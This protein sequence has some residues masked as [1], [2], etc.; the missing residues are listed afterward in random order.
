MNISKLSI[1]RGVTF[2]M[3]YLIA[4][5]FG[6]YGLLQ[7]KLDL[8]PS[9]EFP[10]V[11][12][13]TNYEGVGPEDVE[14]LVTRPL[15]STVI[16][17][18]GVKRVTSQSRT[19]ASVVFIEFN[20]GTDMA[21]AENDVRKNIDFVRDFFPQEVSEPLT[22]AFN[23]SLQPILFFN[24]SS[25]ILGDAE[26]RK[27]AEEQIQPRLE[28]LEGVARIQVSGGLEREIQVLI[29][30]Y[31]L[32]ANS[33]SMDQLINALRF[34]NLE[35][36]GGILEEGR[37][38]FAIKT[39]AAFE[40]V[41]QIRNAVVGYSKMGQP[42]YLQNV[43]NLVDGYKEQTQVVRN[44]RKNTIILIAY[45]QT[46]ANTVN[47]CENVIN[48]LPNLEKRIG[49]DV[50]FNVIYN[51]A[52][53]INKSIRNLSSTAIMAFFLSALVLF[54]FLRSFRSSLIVA[55]SIPVSIIVTFFVMS[56]LGLT[57]NIISM[58]G[59]ALAV[60]LLVDNSIV[61]LENIFRRNHD[62]NELIREAAEKGSQEVGTAITASTLTTISVFIPILFV[63][64]IS[65]ELFKDM[66][67][68]IVV[69]LVTSLLVA[70]TL[71]PL[72][73]SRL[74]SR[75]Q[76]QHK[77]GI[78][79]LFDK[80][81][82]KSIDY[83]RNTYEKH[84]RVI[85]RHKKITMLV[86][87]VL[88]VVTGI[89][90]SRLGGEFI[91]EADE[92]SVAFNIEAEVGTSLPEMDR[93]MTQIE[94]LIFGHYPEVTNLYSNFG[95]STGFGALFGGESY[96]GS[97]RLNLLDKSE[98]DRTQKEIQDELREQLSALPGLKMSF[99][100]GGPQTGGEG[101]ISVKIFGEDLI[102]GKEL[103]YQIEALMKTI[104]GLVDIS[105]SFSKPQPEYQIHLDRD[106]ISRLGLN[107]GSVAQAVST[108][109][110]G[111]IATRYREGADEYDVFVRYERNFRT[112]E[113]DL[114]NILITTPAGIQ[115]PLSNIA[116]IG[117]D[118]G[119]VK[120]DREDQ[121]R[122]V[123]VNA[124]NSGR[125]LQSITEDLNRQLATLSI[126]PDFRL[127]IGGTA[128]DLQESFMYLGLA[129]LIA[130][131]L[132]YMVMASQFESLLD[133]F[134][135]LF[136]LPLAFIGVIFALVISGT[137]IS[138]TVFI[139]GMLLVGIVVN[140][141]IVMIDYINQ[142]LT[143]K[144]LSLE[145]AVVIGAKTRFRPVLM[146]ALTTI[147]SMIPLAFELGSSAEIWAPMARAVI[148][149]LTFSTFLTLIF[150]PV[151]YIIFQRR[152]LDRKRKVFAARLNEA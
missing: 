73:A 103:A 120:I 8:Y 130:I 74:L 42:I 78:M 37:R 81:V 49:G 30:P 108:A 83:G 114:K 134:I 60:G 76:Q 2:A 84:L 58:A 69:S 24:V 34:S 88:V 29:D 40:S 104:P 121:A 100:Q 133:P 98:R 35:I 65:G 118:L 10:L 61:V 12:I 31:Q 139:G 124:G 46:D 32:A 75:K 115:I 113:T 28:R 144:K 148:G 127:E 149:G 15:E 70:L 86:I 52:E 59:L 57:L 19:G 111:S 102:K 93:I 90:A 116:S 95:R 14:N 96:K 152:N 47:A 136:T 39:N 64:G 16:S 77:T 151:M 20:W 135:I 143:D 138:I 43:A 5:G 54:F 85:I 72:L 6:I 101:A 17:V 142:L 112:D 9:L 146:T 11:G 92:S 18:E 48:Y 150:V 140:N 45:K 131:L 71:I 55:T 23:P 68:T 137:N 126:P 3:I 63:P 82:G 132:V 41:D 119:P 80:Y 125:D 117:S 1:R 7:L 38:E 21:K 110:K 56:Q 94:E 4:I 87:L 128:K 147:L 44:N 123:A 50:D 67:L 33:L 89:A 51:Q 36:P 13:I 97:I 91:P 53:F 105:F 145:E 99:T 79:N 107:V 141:G 66:A 22:F 129:I 122:Y 106:R 109:M 26:L 62:E 27:I 25:E